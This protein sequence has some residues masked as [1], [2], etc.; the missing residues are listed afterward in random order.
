VAAGVR[1]PAQGDH[2][3]TVRAERATIDAA[4]AWLAAHDPVTGL[5]TALGFAWAWA[6]LGAGR[7]AADRIRSLIT[8]DAGAA[9]RA[10]GHLFAAW[11]EAAGGD[12]DRALA[13]IGT[14]S[15]IAGD[16]PRVRLFRAFAHSQAGRPGTALDDL[17]GI[18][19]AGWE[20][21]AAWLLRAWSE[22]ALGRTARAGKAC[23]EALRLLDDDWALGHA[24]ALLGTLATAEQRYPD[25]V[26]HLARATAAAERLGFAATGALHRAGLGRALHLNGEAA[27]A[28]A[29]LEQAVATAHAAGDL[30][31]ATLARVRLAR[32]LRALGRD[33]DARSHLAT[34]RAWYATAG[35]GDGALLADHLAAALDDDRDALRRI[36][37]RHDPETEALSLDALARLAAADGRTAEAAGLLAEADGLVPAHLVTPADRLD[38]H[39]AAELLEAGVSPVP[40][41]QRRRLSGGPR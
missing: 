35:G 32:V 3:A 18:D 33:G 39:R 37:A 13:E 11:F 5:R 21:G 2:L 28:V 25:A 9:E 23:G 31:V 15:R 8:P 27:A 24:E 10:D 38:R 29:A 34:A 14:A 16:T 41:P 20:L 4:L 40:P 1:G 17:A 26:A 7:D 36:A 30:R 19:A 6:F 12:L 22:I